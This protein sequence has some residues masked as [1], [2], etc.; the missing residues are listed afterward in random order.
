MNDPR[1]WSLIWLSMAIVCL[2]GSCR[3]VQMP[4]GPR[5]SASPSQ[6]AASDPTKTNGTPTSVTTG[7]PHTFS[8]TPMPVPQPG[9]MQP[10]LH[11]PVTLTVIYD[12]N[13]FDAR[14]KTEWGLACLIE[15]DGKTI[16]FDTGGD[17]PTLMD[18][19]TTLGFDPDRIDA[20]VLSHEHADHV[21]GLNAVLSVNHHLSVFVPRSF[22]ST[23]LAPVSKRAGVIRVHDPV[24]ITEHVRTTG[25]MGTTIVE[26]SL[27]V[28]T[29]RGLVVITGCAHPG[30]VE[31]VRHAQAEGAIYL[32]LGGLHLGDASPGQVETIVQELKRVGVQRVAPCHCTGEAATQRFQAGFPTDFI[33]TGVGSQ[34]VLDGAL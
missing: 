14:L 11:R 2:L 22:S 1:R 9:T 34:I 25:E 29:A 23:F 30:I 17:G 6:T 10:S 32:I 21:G 12:N 28:E 24:T 3:M 15:I 16:L 4:G 26:Q 5:P 27:L 7:P 33:L 19:L 13:P 18:N 31:I 20:V 8:Y